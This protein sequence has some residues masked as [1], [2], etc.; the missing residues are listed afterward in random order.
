MRSILVALD[1]SARA[2]FVF[3][4]AL[5][6]AEPYDAVLHPFRA[7]FVP[8]EYPP[9]SAGIPA[10][11][12]PAHLA[13][14]AQDELLQL[15]PSAPR[16][17]VADPIIRVGQPWRLILEVGDALDVDLVVIGSHGYHGVDR[18]LGTTAA[19]VVNRARRNV[20]VVHARRLRTTSRGPTDHE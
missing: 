11:P 18:I 5:E 17:R 3:D 9:G 20:L 15:V 14:L 10:D 4:T 19:R 2:R 12:L 1:G 7:V 13:K 6:L 8:P 16:T